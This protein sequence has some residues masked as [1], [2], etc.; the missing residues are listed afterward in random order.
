MSPV[1]L[2]R[3]TDTTGVK[4][5]SCCIVTSTT[6]TRQDSN[7]FFVVLP[8]LGVGFQDFATRLN[9]LDEIVFKMKSLKWA[10]D[11]E[12]MGRACHAELLL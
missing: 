12:M 1:E 3:R 6:S 11:V 7:I 10:A 8:Y 4:L 5:C 2:L 9:G